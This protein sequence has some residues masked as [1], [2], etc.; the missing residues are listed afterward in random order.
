MS[1]SLNKS[2]ENSLEISN[3]FSC[4]NFMV[5]KIHGNNLDIYKDLYWLCNTDLLNIYYTQNMASEFTNC[6]NIYDDVLV[7]RP[8]IGFNIL[9]IIFMK[10]HD[11]LMNIY[12]QVFLKMPRNGFNI[13]EQNLI[14]DRFRKNMSLFTESQLLK[15]I[16]QLN[17]IENV[18]TQPKYEKILNISESILVY[19]ALG[20]L[21]FNNSIMSGIR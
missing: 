11:I 18:F 13:Y 14:R 3:L 17:I 2:P 15:P 4:N 5:E 7:K 8:R 20:F 10:R 21:I 9:N 19:K 6:F 1:L 12:D 16:N